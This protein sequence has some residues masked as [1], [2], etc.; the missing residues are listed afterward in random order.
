MKDVSGFGREG[1]QKSTA[2]YNAIHQTGHTVGCLVSLL[3]MLIF[4]IFQTDNQRKNQ[5]ETGEVQKLKLHQKM[6]TEPT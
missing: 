3:F 4:S 5:L 1:E 6:T 2:I